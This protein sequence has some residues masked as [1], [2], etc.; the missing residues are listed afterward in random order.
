MQ[1]H[2]RYV[3]VWSGWLRLSHWVIAFGVLFEIASAWAV[4][5]QNVDAA[6]WRD[7]H[8][9][10]GQI[11]LIALLLRLVLL[12]LPGSSNWRQLIPTG[13]DMQAIG[14]MTKFYVTFARFPLPAWYAHNPFWKPLYLLFYLLLA[15][16]LLSGIFRTA[17]YLVAGFSLPTLHQGLA[18]AIILFSIV[19]IITAFLHD[20]K[21]KGAFISAI[22]NGYRYFHVSDEGIGKT[23]AVVKESAVY[24]SVESIRKTAGKKQD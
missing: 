19:H 9:I 17:P 13:T 5:H 18:Q 2:I 11:V 21:G 12:F 22:I 24:I 23:D 16:C 14:Q 4:T 8:T 15:G 10:V 3:Q 20:L 7:W 1:E 6:F